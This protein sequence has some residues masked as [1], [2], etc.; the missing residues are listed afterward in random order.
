MWGDQILRYSKESLSLEYRIFDTRNLR[1]A[2]N[3]QPKIA[4]PLWLF[5][6]I[7]HQRKMAAKQHWFHVAKVNSYLRLYSPLPYGSGKI[8]ARDWLQALGGLAIGIASIMPFVGRY[9]CPGTVADTRPVSANSARKCDCHSQ[10]HRL[11]LRSK[12]NGQ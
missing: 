9:V 11:P 8:Y 1:Q 5:L 12:G 2:E 4:K 10:L 6:P 3:R 7:F